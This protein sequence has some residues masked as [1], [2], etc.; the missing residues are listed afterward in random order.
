MK[1]IAITLL[2]CSSLVAMETED[3]LLKIE[4][5]PL[6]HEIVPESRSSDTS[7]S[8]LLEYDY[9]GLLPHHG[10]ESHAKSDEAKAVDF[11][12]KNKANDAQFGDMEKIWHHAGPCSEKNNGPRSGISTP[13]TRSH[14]PI[15]TQL[16]I[17]EEKP[18]LD[19]NRFALELFD[20]IITESEGCNSENQKPFCLKTQAEY[21]VSR[22]K[23]KVVALEHEFNMMTADDSDPVDAADYKKLWETIKDCKQS[24][25]R[26]ALMEEDCAVIEEC[27]QCPAIINKTLLKET[28][29]RYMQRYFERWA[30]K[31]YPS[32][33]EIIRLILPYCG[34]QDMQSLF[35]EALA[36]NYSEILA[37]LAN[38]ESIESKDI[39]EALRTSI[40]RGEFTTTKI[41]LK[42]AKKH[43][44]I[45]VNKNDLLY[46]SCDRYDG[47]DQEKEIILR[48]LA[49]GADINKISSDGSTLL[50]T[51]LKLNAPSAFISFL[52]DNGASVFNG[53]QIENPL[54]YCVK[55]NEDRLFDLFN[56]LPLEHEEF[57]PATGVILNKLTKWHKKA[58]EMQN[59]EE[60]NTA[61]WISHATKKFGNYASMFE[62]VGSIM[63]EKIK[64]KGVNNT[65]YIT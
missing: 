19:K 53:T 16:R 60:K 31:L 24:L 55:R 56:A 3:N 45:D 36:G 12:L 32:E 47:D 6:L 26:V 62:T 37:I 14:S 52:I 25:F 21:E 34:A 1:S 38:N 35:F 48:L 5:E 4:L 64:R 15:S 17:V 40:R 49:L 30:Q 27:I 43:D 42:A 59:R 46:N 28:I 29:Q 22:L 33:S 8:S 20:K 57:L 9:A 44:D 11:Y 39:E 2:F 58:V 54:S 41:L 18:H 10:T 7:D 51:A 13:S 50:L 65:H 23:G 63:N 61:D